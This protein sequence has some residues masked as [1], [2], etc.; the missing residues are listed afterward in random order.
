MQFRWSGRSFRSFSSKCKSKHEGEL[1]RMTMQRILLAAVIGATIAGL[2]AVA[3]AARG[4]RPAILRGRLRRGGQRRRLDQPWRLEF[5][6]LGLAGKLCRFLYRPG[7]HWC[8]ECFVRLLRCSYQRTEQFRPRPG[9]AIAN[10]GTGGPVGLQGPL[11]GGEILVPHG[12]LS[13]E[14]LA[15]SS[16]YT[17]Q[18][19]A[20]LGLTPGSYV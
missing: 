5:H 19:F 4:L 15:D 16:T 17:N 9:A 3:P 1:S 7:T 6:Q 10:S 13:G 18:T 11:Q 12:Y 2:G 20:S 8:V 14:P